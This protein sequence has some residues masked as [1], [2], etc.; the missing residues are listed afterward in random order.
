MSTGCHLS[1]QAPHDPHAVQTM[2]NMRLFKESHYCGD[3]EQRPCQGGQLREHLVF[4]RADAAQT[5]ASRESSP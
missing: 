3:Q 4:F 2:C 1:T 5:G